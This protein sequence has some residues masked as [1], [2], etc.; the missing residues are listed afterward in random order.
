[1]KRHLIP[2]AGAALALA[3]AAGMP[4]N[5][6]A[7]DADLG[8]K[9]TFSMTGWSA[10]YKH[11]EGTGVVRCQNGG[12]AHVRIEVK[13]GGL[14]A[15]KWH[16]DNG[17]G[18]FSDVHHLSDIYGNYAQAEAQAGVVKSAT[19]QVLSKGT[20]SLALAGTGEGVN[21]GVSFGSFK[22]SPAK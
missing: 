6:R 7:A 10:I 4:T 3:I 20:V 1:M 11:A 18:N 16:I 12:T 22:I 15:G 21:L 2:M 17:H 5:A 19:A 14:T 13:G 9:M 8:C